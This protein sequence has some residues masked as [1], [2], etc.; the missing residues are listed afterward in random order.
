MVVAS[1][2]MPY[3]FDA[4][5][6]IRAPKGAWP[7]V[8]TPNIGMSGVT[9][10]Q[11]M[12]VY[13][14]ELRKWNFEQ[15]DFLTYQLYTHPDIPSSGFEP[16]A[17]GDTLEGHVGNVHSLESIDNIEQLRFQFDTF[18]FDLYADDSQYGEID[19]KIAW[20]QTAYPESP[21]GGYV[22]AQPFFPLQI[23][24]LIA[25]NFLHP[26]LED[27]TGGDF[28]TTTDDHWLGG[29]GVIYDIDCGEV[30]FNP[31]PFP[32]FG[33]NFTGTTDGLRFRFGPV[34][35]VVQTTLGAIPSVL[36]S[37]YES[38]TVTGS[39][40]LQTNFA[41]LE[42]GVVQIDGYCLLP[43]TTMELVKGN[44][45]NFEQTV[46]FTNDYTNHVQGLRAVRDG[47]G[48]NDSSARCYRT[49][50]VQSSGLY[51][52]LVHNTKANVPTT[53]IPSG[54]V[55][56]FPQGQVRKLSGTPDLSPAINSN[57][58]DGQQLVDRGNSGGDAFELDQNSALGIHVMND[59]IWTTGPH[60]SGESSPPGTVLS[61]GLYP[62][63]PY[64]GTPVWYRPAELTI[65][66]TGPSATGYRPIP[67][68]PGAFGYHLGLMDIGGQFVRVSQIFR[69]VLTPDADDALDEFDRSVFFQRYNKTTL[70][71]AAETE[72]NF[73]MIGEDADLVAYSRID[74]CVY[75]GSSI[76]VWNENGTI[77]RFNSSYTHTG[78][79]LG[80]GPAIAR[81]RHWDGS[82]LL[83]T[84][85]G[86]IQTGD[87]LL[88]L[89]GG[90]GSSSGIG[91]WSISV[92]PSAPA[93]EAGEFT[94][95][96]AKPTRL[97]KFLQIA[98]S[99]V[100]IHQI[101]EVTG[102]THV[103]DGVW[104]FFQ[105]DDDMWLF[106]IIERG[107][108]WEAVEGTRFRN[109]SAP[110]IPFGGVPE[111]FPWEGILHDID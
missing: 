17:N 36:A 52:L 56:L 23:F 73:V 66:S 41:A 100:I 4:P 91:V 102:S 96:S 62:I 13:N 110:S 40:R 50:T 45:S 101:F 30:V 106:R 25:A 5:L 89:T 22:I 19:F 109:H 44:D 99:R 42:S 31:F 35:P 75:D 67:P 85:G 1:G 74:G 53:A 49:P 37:R 38:D 6:P 72:A 97:E 39:F 84:I 79:F 81:R 65:A 15:L 20:L 32:R 58:I 70:D 63:S 60:G 24:S 2:Q 76:Y 71:H 29:S 51:R 57:L 9:I 34:Y 16:K 86:N 43:E 68:Q 77:D 61:R 10:E 47:V 80:S 83:Y 3:E 69:A 103:R 14:A 48:R 95:D 12:F 98:P 27:V 46:T 88:S 11:A 82:Q 90:A 93:D 8:N 107:S 94:H 26:P 18:L 105:A 21:S 59:A 64:T 28:I 87:P 111:E 92:E 104:M 78:T 33:N 55:S 7:G 54:F 108:F